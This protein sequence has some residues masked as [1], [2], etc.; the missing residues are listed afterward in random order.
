M[1]ERI[2][3]LYWAKPF[4]PF[5]ICLTDGRSIPVSHPELLSISPSGRTVSVYQL[6]NSLS[7]IN[8]SLVTDVILKPEAAAAKN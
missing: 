5:T 4:Q 1:L 2:R 8:L 3:E 7:T 6:D